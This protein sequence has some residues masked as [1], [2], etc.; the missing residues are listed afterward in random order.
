MSKQ[1][2]NLESKTEYLAEAFAKKGEILKTLVFVSSTGNIVVNKE[3]RMNLFIERCKSLYVDLIER[4]WPV[5]ILHGGLN[6]GQR[7]MGI[8][9]FNQLV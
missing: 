6:T 8:D 2:S 7:M 3:I 9:K 4:G 5:L 1:E